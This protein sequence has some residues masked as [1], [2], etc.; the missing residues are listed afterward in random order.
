MISVDLETR[1]NVDLLACGSWNYATDPSTEIICLAYAADYGTVQHWHPGMPVPSVFTEPHTIHAW[2]ADGFERPMWDFIMGPDH[3]FPPVTL[4]Q[5][6]CTAFKSRCNNLP[7]AL[8]N[9]A[10]CLNVPEQKNYRGRELI[11]LLCQPMADGTFCQDPELLQEMYDYCADDVR[12][13]MAVDKLLREPTDD[14]W[15]DWRVNILINER[16]IRID[17]ALCDAAQVYAGDEEQDLLARIAELTGGEIAKARG[18]KLKAWV[19]DRLTEDQAQ[20]LVK[21]R[22]GEK[23]FSLDKY[24]RSRLLALD[25]MDVDVAEVIECSD[26]AQKSSVGKFKAASLR[27]DPEDDR[28]RGALLCNGAPA[29]G[30]YSSRGLQVHNFPRDGLEY[31]E[32]VRADLIDGIMPEDV[33]SYAGHPIMTVLSRMLRPSLIPAPGCE[34]LVSDWSAI[35][36]RVSPWLCDSTLGDRKVS[37]Y[38]DD[39]PVYE[40]AA[41]RTFRC[42]VEDVTK[43]QRQVGK[44]QELAFQYGGG[45]NAFLAMARNYGLKTS[46]KDAER[47]KDDWRG[48]NPWAQTVWGD[49]ERAAKLAV[50]HPTVQYK[51]GRVTY[52]AV[53]GILCGGTTLFCQLPCGRVLTYPDVRIETK[54]TPWGAEMP[55]LTC[56]RAAFQP[57]M[58]ETEW[59][60]AGLWGGLLHENNTQGT[61]ASLLRY[62]LRECEE[63]ALGVVLHCHDEIVCEV[64]VTD[65]DAAADEL[66][67]IMN[68]APAWAASLPLAASVDQMAR[69]GK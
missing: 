55:S 23:M 13:E 69:Y 41:A 54:T 8:G 66:H 67:Y 11:K 30:R 35:E 29:S 17:R 25:D 31:P 42:T 26:F 40:I 44:V 16:G 10:R 47:Y 68:T 46:L 4:Q 38:A 59:P 60:R 27:A 34:F 24:N 39:E 33:C 19:L 1:S 12:A 7:N 58:T 15:V 52:F 45:S 6:R 28:V 64:E 20:L 50:S 2:N 62:A 14:E 21:Y 63:S 51:A 61:A 53:E 36:G 49:L 3:G 5:W 57:K 32:E 56:L 37:Q 18:E 48:A 43:D 65:L 9:A 22:N